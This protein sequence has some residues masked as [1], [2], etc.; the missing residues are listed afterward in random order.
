MKDK[1]LNFNPTNKGIIMILLINT[2]LFA[3]FEGTQDS[4]AEDTSSEATDSS[5]QPEDLPAYDFVGLDLILTDAQ[6]YEP[7]SERI[8]IAFSSDEA[9]DFSGDCNL[10]TGEYTVDEDIFN[11]IVMTRTEMGCSDELMTEDDWLVSFF[12]GSPTF[13]FS[14]DGSMTFQSSDATLTFSNEYPNINLVGILWEV[15]GYINGDSASAWNL[16][17]NPSFT[18][19]DDGTIE[20]NTGCNS[21]TGQYTFEDAEIS[22][23]NQSYTLMSCDDPDIMEMEEHVINV[24]SGSTLSFSID[25]NRL[26]LMNGGVGLTAVRR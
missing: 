20:L 23:T 5:E 26:T 12:D 13:S 6:G 9:F 15:D 24:F 2:I 3:C 11:G 17:T 19:L 8:S 1:T 25:Q 21:G 18:F 7:V 10:F 22:V 4:S 14:E 16:E